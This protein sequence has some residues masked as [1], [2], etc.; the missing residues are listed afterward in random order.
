[1]VRLATECL[2][3]ACD[4]ISHIFRYLTSSNV[5]CRWD[6]VYYYQWN[7]TLVLIAFVI[8]CPLSP[9]VERCRQCV[10]LASH[11]FGSYAPTFPIAEKALLIT[12]NS[13]RRIDPVGWLGSPMQRDEVND[14]PKVVAQQSNELDLFSDSWEQMNWDFMREL[15]DD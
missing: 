5:L 12:Q 2:N 15:S 8:A 1:M 6:E 10:A 14:A 3:I 9:S 7:A 4:T 11:V 13:F